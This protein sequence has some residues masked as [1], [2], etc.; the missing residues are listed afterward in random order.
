[1]SSNPTI[2]QVHVNRPLTNLSVAYIQDQN[3]FIA[4]KVFPVVP[5]S[6]KSDDYYVYDKETFARAIAHQ[7]EGAEESKGSGWKVGT[8]TYKCRQ[9][10]FHHDVPKDIAENNDAP[11]EPFKDAVDFVTRA[12]LLKREKDFID[13]Y[14]RSGVWTNEEA[15]VANTDKWDNYTDSDPYTHVQNAV[16]TVQKACLVKPNVLL[17]SPYAFDA[18]ANHPDLKDRYKYTTSES[19]T[20]EMLARVLKIERVLVGEAV[21][22]TS[23]EGQTSTMDYM[24]GKNALLVYAARR[25]S[26]LMPSAGYI[27]SW[28]AF[29]NKYG[30]RITRFPMKH[31][32]NAERVEGDM[33]YDVK[34]VC[35]D[36]GYFFGNVVS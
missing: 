6:K 22:V 5:V 12:M 4:D 23:N 29:G 31:L 14:V 25:P 16:R 18:L 9:Q 13:A 20:A 35:A 2:N 15:T 32:N 19:L 26:I 21:S 3:E 33:A 17:L 28:N 7:R 10:S 11:L 30:A 27:F 1:M 36:A 24:M 8:D 34:V